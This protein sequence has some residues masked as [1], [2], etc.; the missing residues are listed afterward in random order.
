LPGHQSRPDVAGPGI[1]LVSH[2]GLDALDAGGNGAA[3]IIK[4]LRT[5]VNRHASPAADVI[6][7]GAPVGILK[8]TPNPDQLPAASPEDLAAMRNYLKDRGGASRYGH[9]RRMYRLL[10]AGAGRLKV[11]PVY[12]C[13]RQQPPFAKT[14]A[15]LNCPRQNA[16]VAHFN[17][18]SRTLIVCGILNCPQTTISAELTPL[19]LKRKPKWSILI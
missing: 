9:D 8:P 16:I 15:N 2:G 11:N 4:Q 3:I 18:L 17:C 6:I 7:V 1:A 13:G 10:K 12:L 5:I 14:V 19:Q